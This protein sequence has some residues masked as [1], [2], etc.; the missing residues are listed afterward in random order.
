MKK[1]EFITSFKWVASCSAQQATS[2][3]DKQQMSKL[4]MAYVSDK[5]D[6][7]S[8]KKHN[9]VHAQVTIVIICDNFK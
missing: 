6:V 1:K 5:Q 4:Q 2:I 3:D 9:K 7:A 8:V